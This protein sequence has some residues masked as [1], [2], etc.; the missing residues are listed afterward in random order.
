[1][2]QKAVQYSMEKLDT[3][4]GHEFEYACAELLRHVG[5]RD[6]KVTQGAGDYGVDILARR[7]N[8]KYAIQC[9][10]YAGN[11]GVKA[12]QEAGMGCDYYHCDAAVVMTN[13]I[14]TKQAVR[15]ANTTGVRLW[16]RDFLQ[17]LINEYDE[18]YDMISPPISVGYGKKN[19]SKDN[20]GERALSKAKEEQPTQRIDGQKVEQPQD[21]IHINAESQRPHAGVME[22]NTDFEKQTFHAEG[23]VK[24]KATAQAGD[25]TAKVLTIILDVIRWL[26]IFP[27]LLVCVVATAAEKAYIAVFFGIIMTYF[28]CPLSRKMDQ[29]FH[30]GIWVKVALFCFSL[31]AWFV[32]LGIELTY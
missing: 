27:V 5:Y 2:E 3:M 10:R 4:E 11:V 26:F 12:I 31:M 9:K 14:F 29:Y 30:I 18:E 23:A 20:E 6:V 16:G 13:S 22:R 17:Q 28:L 15:F 32:A 19:S 8:V 21:S 7:G 25:E 24:K 1:M